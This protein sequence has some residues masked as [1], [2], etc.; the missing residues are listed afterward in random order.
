MQ[1]LLPL[2]KKNGILAIGEWLDFG[3]VSVPTGR[4]LLALAGV[5]FL[6]VCLFYQSQ[7]LKHSALQKFNDLLHDFGISI[8]WPSDTFLQGAFDEFDKARYQ[9]L[10]CLIASIALFGSSVLVVL[11]TKSLKAYYFS[12]FLE[13]IGTCLLF[14]SVILP[15]SRNYVSASNVQNFLPSCGPLFDR[16]V[17]MIL[18]N[19][20][21]L[22]SGLLYSTGALPL[23]ILVSPALV[24]SCFLVTSNSHNNPEIFKSSLYLMICS[25]LVKNISFI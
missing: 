17:H 23:L 20:I 16:A 2:P 8:T 19:V 9:E 22:Y 24:R 12:V 15:G 13:V 11:C 14:V 7:D 6:A 10:A 25:S 1:P 5:L 3:H 4:K 21:G 18:G